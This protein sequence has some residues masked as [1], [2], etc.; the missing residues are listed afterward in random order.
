METAH[1]ETKMLYCWMCH[2][3][4][5]DFLMDTCSQCKNVYCRHDDDLT[6]KHVSC[7][8][9]VC[10]D[11]LWLRHRQKQLP[12]LDDMTD[13]V[14]ELEEHLQNVWIRSNDFCAHCASVDFSKEDNCV[15]CFSCDRKFC[16]AD[17]VECME[18]CTKCNGL[19]CFHCWDDCAHAV[20]N[21][22]QCAN[23]DKCFAPEEI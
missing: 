11:C 18:L 13:E 5:K 7:D 9:D 6:P 8:G 22:V 15:V 1:E 2:R 20:D 4:A 23:K 10:D 17:A 14:K 16:T 21:I 12:G 19:I 3:Y